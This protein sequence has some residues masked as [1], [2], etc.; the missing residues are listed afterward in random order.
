MN[1]RLCNSSHRQRVL[2]APVRVSAAV[3]RVATQGRLRGPVCSALRAV[4]PAAGA[5][6]SK[7]SSVVVHSRVVATVARTRRC[8]GSAV[9]ERT[10]AWRAGR[11]S[12]RLRVQ[13]CSAQRRS[14][15]RCCERQIQVR[16]CLRAV[17]WAP[18]AKRPVLRALL[19]L[20]AQNAA[21]RSERPNPSI[22]RTSKRLRLF[23]AAHVER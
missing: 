21:M 5:L 11:K 14:A 15:P 1:G 16:F 7:R 8:A 10:H 23:D 2:R 9:Q 6:A 4:R 20:R 17:G 13:Q 22:E 18:A 3:S 12:V 19:R